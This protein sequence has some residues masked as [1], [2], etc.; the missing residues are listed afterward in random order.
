VYIHELTPGVMIRPTERHEW[1][2]SPIDKWKPTK[3]AAPFHQGGEG[4]N[5]LIDSGIQHHSSLRFKH[6][7]FGALKREIGVYLGVKVLN[8]FYFGIKKH[9]MVL[10]NGT[11]CAIDGYQ[12]KDV[13]KV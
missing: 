2:M 1:S 13:E 6:A 10:I 9:H 7:R 3:T 8:N 11:L 5:E 4:A 12:F